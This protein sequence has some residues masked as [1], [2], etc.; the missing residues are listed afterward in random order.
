M[1][2][3]PVSIIRPIRMFFI[4]ERL[5][6]FSFAFVIL[7]GAVLLSQPIAVHGPPLNFIDALFTATSATCVTG[8]I[9]V[10]TAT[11]F[12]VYGQ[13]VIL[14]LIQLGG[15]GIMT[16]S[17]AFFYLMARRLSIGNKGLLEASFS[18]MPMQG[19]RGLLRTIFTATF[20]IEGIG[21]AILSIRFVFDMP[22]QKALYFGVFHAVSAFCNAGFALFSDSLMSYQNDFV[23]TGTIALLIIFG[24][25]GFVVLYE[26]HQKQS[27]FNMLSLN[28]RIVLSTTIGLLI[29][30]FVFILL[31]ESGNTLSSLSWPQKIL[32]AFFQSVTTR[33]AGFNSLDIGHLSNATLF[34]MIILMYIGASPSSTGGGIKT[35]TLATI[36]AFTRSRF[37]NQEHTQVFNRSLSGSAVSKAVTIVIFSSFTVILFTT[38]LLFTELSGHSHQASRG[39]FMELLFE[40]TS[41]IATVGL[42]TGV[43]PHLSPAGRVLIT[44]VMFIGRL[45]PLT[46]ALAIG[47][48][49]P[50]KFKYVKEEILI[51]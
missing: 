1:P 30:G 21:A 4:P 22:W 16:F 19:M 17:V 32:H 34:I 45:G 10:D 36:L 13:V 6:I 40:V 47:K 49:E 14:F 28:S 15:L 46:T 20:I 8:L 43:T 27:S 37:K 48:K 33:T 35:T 38:L 9:V 7:S 42:S 12:T 26:L 2:I 29:F 3:L 24:G 23:V 25:L 39:L 44:L 11:R 5:F 41:A 51:G 18:Q 50:Q 31:F